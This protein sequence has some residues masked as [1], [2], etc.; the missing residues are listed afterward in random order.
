MRHTHALPTPRFLL[1]LAFALVLALA[2]ALSPAA[3]HGAS[4]EYPPVINNGDIFLEGG[5]GLGLPLHA[6]P[7]CPPLSLRLDY[8]L[9]LAGLPFTVGL[10]G[11]FSTEKDSSLAALNAGAAFRL[12]WHL[13]L[14]IPRLD[15]YLLA[16]AGA[17]FSSLEHKAAPG[18]A[19]GA[20]SGAATETALAPWLGLGAG[21]RYFFRPPLGAYLEASLG[22]LKTISLGLSLKL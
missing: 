14:D 7:R 12:A 17:L 3:L 22:I 8:A 19:S 4:F 6:V 21:A 10:E 13:G 20:A 11:A 1:A 5:L 18:A 15:A 2:L 16:S 9:P